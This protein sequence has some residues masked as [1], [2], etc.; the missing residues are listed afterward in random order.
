M[1]TRDE[2]AEWVKRGKKE[3]YKFIVVVC[4]TFDYEDYPVFCKNA[5]E[6]WSEYEKHNGKNRQKVMEVYDLTKDTDM[7]LKQGRVMQLPERR[8]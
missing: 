5:A 4:D 8:I 1:T 2:I 3:N 7:Q 6:C